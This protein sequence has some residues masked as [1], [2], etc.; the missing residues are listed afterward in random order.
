MACAQYYVLP[1]HLKWGGRCGSNS[2]MVSHP[3]QSTP[4]DK[5]PWINNPPY[6]RDQ[7]KFLLILSKRFQLPASLWNY[8]NK[9]ITFSC[10]N[11]GSL[12]PPDITKL[13]SHSP[14]L[15]I[16]FPRTTLWPC[17]TCCVFP[18]GL[19]IRD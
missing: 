13:V 14:C 6:H 19:S 8:L 7:A 11:Q 5:V 4:V 18:W 2:L 17:V 12:H 10:G 15:F 9:L 16:L 3:L 1:W